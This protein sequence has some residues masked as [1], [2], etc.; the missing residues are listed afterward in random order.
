MFDIGFWELIVIAIVAL[1]VIGPD[2]LPGF[3][4]E[5]GRW[6][7]KLRRVINNTRREL[8]REL[9]LSEQTGLDHHLSELDDLIHNAPDQDPDYVAP[10]QKKN[11]DNNTGT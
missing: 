4:R 11:N 8:E 9:Q 3:A 2:R 1:L 6:I 7:S 10:M 5:T